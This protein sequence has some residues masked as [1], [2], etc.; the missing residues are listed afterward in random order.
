[1]SELIIYH[2]LDE[3]IEEV[4]SVF[5]SGLEKQ[6][7]KCILYFDDVELMKKCDNRIWTFSSEKF[8]PHCT[9]FDDMPIE[10][11]RFWLT[12]ELKNL[13]KFE[14]ICFVYN[15]DEVKKYIENIYNLGLEGK[16]KK[17]FLVFTGLLDS[18]EYSKDIDLD[19]FSSCKFFNRI[20]KTWNVVD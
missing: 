10:L 13:D 4:V 5:C 14:N 19:K 18:K 6:N 20:N 15:G 9:N 3:E 7:E 8:I 17:I 11:Q 1:M 16:I 2:I 12:N